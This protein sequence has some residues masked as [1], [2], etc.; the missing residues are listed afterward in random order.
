MP[1]HIQY[2]DDDLFNPETHH[3]STDVPV[4]PLFWFIVIFIVFAA[5]SHVALWFLYKA[6][7]KIE[8]NRMNP[9]A[10]AIQRPADADVPKNQ[11]LL[12]PFPIAEKTPQQT[13]PVS[14]M[15]NMLR[16][17]NGTLRSYGWVDKQR[18]IVHMPIE[19]A[20]ELMAQRMA[21]QPPVTPGTVAVPAASEAPAAPAPA[22]TTGGT[23]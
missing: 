4:R 10:T 9:P 14:D 1:D 15:A 22:T 7:V 6:F 19:R 3:E 23:Q 17:Q 11:P 13:T 18:G 8:R 5:V 16:E 21:S 2:E 20:K 12:Q